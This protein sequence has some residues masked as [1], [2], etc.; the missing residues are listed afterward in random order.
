MIFITSKNTIKPKTVRSLCSVLLR[1]RIAYVSYDEELHSVY[2]AHFAGLKKSNDFS[3]SATD[4]DVVIS[5]DDT[6]IGDEKELLE[7]VNIVYKDY[8]LDT[9]KRF[10]PLDS[11]LRFLASGGVN[12]SVKT[13]FFKRKF[14]QE[15]NIRFNE[16]VEK[17]SEMLFMT[18]CMLRSDDLIFIS[19]AFVD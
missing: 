3:N 14:L 7:A 2:E 17:N 15:N 1:V 16:S 8:L 11:R 9:Q 4:A 10:I 12:S 19:H 18:E 13:K 5:V 6:T